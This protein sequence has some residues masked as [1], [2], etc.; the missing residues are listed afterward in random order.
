MMISPFAWFERFC[1]SFVQ[2]EPQSKEELLESLRHAHLHHNLLP[3][4]TLAMIEGA[5]QVSDMHVRDIMVPRAQMITLDIDSSPEELTKLIAEFGHSRYPV[6]GEDKDDVQGIFLAKDLLDYYA[7]DNKEYFNLRDRMRPA[8]FIPESK[9][10]NVLLREFRTSRN[11]MAIVVNEYSGAAG[12]I[13]IEDVIEQIVGDIDDEHDIDDEN[14]ITAREGFFWVWALTPI[15]EF[16][17]FFKTDFTDEEFDTVGGLITQ[18]FGHVPKRGE[19]LT[20]N[21]LEFEVMRSNNRRV[22]LL[23]VKSA[24]T[25]EVV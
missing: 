4:D 21:N 10:L 24:A 11:H 15:E 1:Q 22:V 20:L 13:T 19:K 8:V 6:I 5:L 3:A 12:L 23:R 18:S 17:E 2:R 16:N 25:A 14:F 9:R 7:Q